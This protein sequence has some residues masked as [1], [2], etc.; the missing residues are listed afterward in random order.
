MY[1][2]IFLSSSIPQ[3]KLIHLTALLF[4][5]GARVESWRA[6][7]PCLPRSPTQPFVRPG[8]PGHRDP[9][10]PAQRTGMGN[11]ERG[12]S[13]SNFVGCLGEKATFDESW[14][15]WNMR[16]MMKNEV[17]PNWRLWTWCSFRLCSMLKMGSFLSHHRYGQCGSGGDRTV[18]SLKPRGS[19]MV[20]LIRWMGQR[21]PNHQLRDVV[22]TSHYFGWVFQTILDWWFYRLSKIHPQYSIYSII[23]H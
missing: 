3:Q 6:S 4:F 19:W 12:S 11:G 13:W 21:N 16:K 5:G 9:A 22:F 7:T 20:C 8:R 14:N 23:E 10:Q 17:C 15:V 2:H 1:T 18:D